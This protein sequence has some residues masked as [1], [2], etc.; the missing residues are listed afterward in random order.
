MKNKI[1]EILYDSDKNAHVLIMNDGDDGNNR[2]LEFGSTK[3]YTTNLEML[4]MLVNVSK[5][6]IKKLEKHIKGF[7][8]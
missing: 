7:K 6:D 2:I 3:D 4:K 8:S 1:I 5:G